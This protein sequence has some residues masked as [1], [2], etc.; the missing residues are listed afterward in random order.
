MIVGY[1]V[2]LFMFYEMLLEKMGVRPFGNGGYLYWFFNSFIGGHKFGG[3][4]LMF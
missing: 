4:E 3:L 1:I 2:L